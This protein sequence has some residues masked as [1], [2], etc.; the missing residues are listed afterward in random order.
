MRWHKK[1]ILVLLLVL[2]SL[3][4]SL[5]V[6][7]VK[8]SS[9]LRD[10]EPRYRYPTTIYGAATSPSNPR[11][12]DVVA[13]WVDVDSH[14]I[15]YAKAMPESLPTITGR[16]RGDTVRF[17]LDDIA[18]P[19]VN[20]STGISRY[21]SLI[22]LD[23]HTPAGV[24]TL[25]IDV[26]QIS[27]EVA[28]F[29]QLVTVV[30]HARFDE[31]I[32]LNSSLLNT[33]DREANTAEA[34][35]FSL[36]YKT[37]S[38]SEQRAHT[39]ILP[40]NGGFAALYGNHR[41]YNGIDLGTYHSGLDIVSSSGTPVKASASGRVIAVK[42]FLV[43]GL[44]IVIDHGYGVFT[45]YSHLSLSKVEENELVTAGQTVGL[46]GSSGRSQGPHLHFEIAVG[47]AAVDPLP[48]LTEPL[49][50]RHE[51]VDELKPAR[52]DHMGTE[53]LTQFH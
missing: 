29:D 50:G 11:P 27:G 13:V 39:F 48:W 9:P 43:H 3:M 6:R 14:L 33:L 36:I 25:T 38:E 46:V 10:L 20:A 22:G 2:M 44:S 52:S 34:T 4:P 47:G 17:V 41:I 37:Y 42:S 40:V 12:G 18:V 19:T 1:S 24:Y 26:K 23:A 45:T 28:H 7:S 31:Y 15:A 49:P 21:L 51:R 5:S 8:A 16:F 32:T 35:A 53:Q 30:S